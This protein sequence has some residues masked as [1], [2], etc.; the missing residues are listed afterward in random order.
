MNSEASG[1]GRCRGLYRDRENGWI[2]GVCAGVADYMNV[3][4]TVVRVIA[5]AG[6][7]FF[8]WVTVIIYGAATLVLK[9]KP[10]TWSGHCQENEFWRCRGRD[11][12]SHS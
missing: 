5:G 2:F 10:L 4:V 6:L 8:F 1:P 7:V 9:E 3:P 12:W 11:D